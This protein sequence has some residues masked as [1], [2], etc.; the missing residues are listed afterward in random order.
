VSYATWQG[1][2]IAVPLAINGQT[3]SFALDTDSNV[4]AISEAEAKRL[5]MRM[6]ASQVQFHGVTGSIAPG[7]RMA[8]ADRLTVGKTEL[9]NVTFVVLRD[10]QEPFVELPL[11]E[12][13]VLG[14][15]VLLAIQTLRWNR[16]HRLDLGFRP[17]RAN[18]RSANLCFEGVDPL[19]EV[20]VGERRLAFLIDTGGENSEAW[21]VFGKEFPALLQEARKGSKELTGYSGSANVEAAILPELRMTLAGFP[22]VFHDA[23]VLL[24][25]TVDA[26]NWHYGRIS[27]DLLNQAKEVT[28]DFNAMRIL[29]K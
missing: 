29:L 17:E 16:E 15:P 3:A 5:G 6:V 20:E 1:G 24:G 10:A 28:L 2:E 12:R 11:G 18:L 25:K 19:A 23:P 27:I 22:I 26:S 8:I 7:A 14:L 9:R 13:G 4:S 21:P